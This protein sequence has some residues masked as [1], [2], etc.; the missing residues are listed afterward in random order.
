MTTSG[1]YIFLFLATVI[2]SS[3]SQPVFTNPHGTLSEPG[4]TSTNKFTEAEDTNSPAESYKMGE[5][6]VQGTLFEEKLARAPGSISVLQQ[7]ELQTGDRMSLTE[8]LDKAPG[9]FVQQGAYN[10]SRVIIRGVGSRTP[11]TSNRIRAYLDEIPLTSGD[12]VSSLEDIDLSYIGKVEVIRGPTGALYGSGMGGTI[13][14]FTEY[15]DKGNRELKARADAELWQKMN[16]PR[17]F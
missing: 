13:R 14:L 7:E 12:G 6:V 5:L 1:S 9:V 17:N 10:T 16:P 4:D 8:Y 2:F 3:T 11:Y 15:P